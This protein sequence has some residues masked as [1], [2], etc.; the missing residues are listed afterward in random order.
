MFLVLIVIYHSIKSVLFNKTD[1]EYFQIYVL[2]IFSVKY[3]NQTKIEGY[4]E[5]LNAHMQV[6][7]ILYLLRL[8]LSFG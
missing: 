5:N 6:K 3:I 8:Q 2:H 1:K 4:V 7:K